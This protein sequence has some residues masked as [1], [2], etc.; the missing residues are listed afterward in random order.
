MVE[1]P[2]LAVGEM[3]SEKLVAKRPDMPE[4]VCASAG[5]RGTTGA[6]RSS[7]SEHQRVRECACGLLELPMR[8]AVRCTA[9]EGRGRSEKDG[10]LIAGNP[11]VKSL[12]DG[13]R[14]AGA[15]A[16]NVCFRLRRRGEAIAFASAVCCSVLPRHV[17][18]YRKAMT[19]M[20]NESIIVAIRPVTRRNS[21]VSYGLPSF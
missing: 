14:S 18:P 12:R 19:A 17:G 10:H 11:E 3:R 16:E 21:H 2:G 7:S 6:S 9:C 4:G 20:M 13:L 1:R 5:G 15:D 8:S